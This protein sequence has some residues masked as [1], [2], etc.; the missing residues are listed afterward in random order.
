MHNTLPLPPSHTHATTTAT[1]YTALY[2]LHPRTLMQQQ[3][4]LCAK[5]STTSTLTHSCNN[6]INYVHS[7]LPL[8][9]SYTHSTTTATKCTALYHFLHR[10]LIQQQ[11]QLSAQHSTTS[12]LTH[13]CN[14]N[15]LQR[16]PPYTH[17]TTTL[18]QLSA[19]HSTTSTLTHP[20]NNCS[21]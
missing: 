5:H 15:T 20:C 12:T 16:Q 2:H 19:Q 3:Q 13:S 4:Q 6:N 9:P 10:T 7:T 17:A 11:Q 21:K 14:S 18:Q 8:P 1:R